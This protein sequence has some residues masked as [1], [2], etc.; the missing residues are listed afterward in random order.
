MFECKI[1]E[2]HTARLPEKP[3]KNQ[4]DV[5]WIPLSELE[6]ITLY[7]NIKKQIIQ[8]AQTRNTIDL[9]EEHTL[10]LNV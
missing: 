9:I 10:L 8:F 5:K 7:P 1:K 6:N 2:G 4:T 3:D